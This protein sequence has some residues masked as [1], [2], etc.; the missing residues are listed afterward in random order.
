MAQICGGGAEHVALAMIERVIDWA[1]RSRGWILCGALVLATL[2]GVQASRLKLDALPDLSDNQIIVRA[3]FPGR[4][5]QLVEDQLTYPLTTALLGLPGATAV[6]GISM[7]GEAYVYVVLADSVAA[8]AVRSRVLER[9]SQLA[10]TLPPGATTA[11][12]PDASGVGWIFQYA[13]LAKNRDITP[14]RL[15]SLQEFVIKPELQ[16]VQG[17]AEVATFGAAARQVQVELDANRL[18]ALGISAG[19]VAEAVRNAN[20]AAGGG[21]LELGRQRVLISADARVR[22]REELLDIPIGNDAKGA[23]LRLRQVANVSYGPAPQ[24]GIADLN[25]AGAVVSGIVVMRKGENADR[26]AA[27]VK[28]AIS[29]LQT[30]LPEGVELVS[31]YDRTKIIHGAVRSLAARLIEEAI[32]VALVCGAFLWRVRSALVIILTLPIGLLCALALLE[33]QDVTANIMSLGGLAIAIGAMV[34]AAV[35]MV[36]ALHRKLERHRAADLSHREL[37][38]ETAREVGPA[39]FFSLLVITLSFLPVLFLQGQEGKLF[40][41][42]ALTKTYAMAAAALLSITLVPVLMGMLIKGPVAPELRNPLN[43]WLMRGY[44]PLLQ[45]VLDRPRTMLALAAVVSVSLLFPLSKMGREFMPPLDEGDLLYMPTTLPDVSLDEAAE[46]LRV[47]DELIRQMPEVA[48]VHGKAGRSDSATDPAPLSMLETT[49]LLKPRAEWPEPITTHE[50][51][52][53]LDERVRLAGLTNSWGFPIATR[54]DMLATGVRTP[55]ALRISG[56]DLTRIQALSERAEE[57]LRGVPGIRA[58]F[59]ERAAS[60]RFLDVELDRTRANLYG[61]RASDL[62]DLIGGAVG[63]EPVDTLSVGRERYP[64]VVRFARAQRDS[65]G[66]LARLP[67]RTA[68]GAIVTLSQIASL[69]VVDGATEIRSENARPVGFVLLD[70]ADRDVGGVL[71]RAREA[72]DRAGLHEPGYTLSWVGQYQRLQAATVRL[73]G[74]SLV[75]LAAIVGVLYW[76]FRCWKRVGV[77]IGSMPFAAS[78]AAWT[79]Y[80]LGYQWSFATAVGFLALAG[81]AAEFCVVMLLYLDHEMRATAALAGAGSRAAS[82]TAVIRGALLRL[83]PKTMTVAVILGGLLPLMMSEGPGVDVMRPVA[84]PVIGGMLTAPLFSLLVVPALYLMMFGVRERQQ[85]VARPR[86]PVAID[87]MRGD[88]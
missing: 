77:V 30:A 87:T 85:Q 73:V 88:A 47:T 18:T 8:D 2:A 11:L 76:H 41:P 14:D 49:I 32:V 12:G 31:T 56:P 66:D 54:I 83:R 39:L 27:R 64:I 80:W 42:L 40:S 35:V 13:L 43:R 86:E 6:R 33:W 29:G 4:P 23:V 37:V 78:G 19:Q 20:R 24:L 3:S 72:L 21:A 10:P 58:A 36:E 48:L 84:A 74:I 82:R 26:V 28:S 1:L 60:G 59:A 46:V 75:T 65:L 70:V 17:V 25:G 16:S 34:D 63:G 53:R 55:L 22:S 71:A 9:L 61:V 57:V 51:I 68:S 15:R 45:A 67:V 81:V 44:R 50:L 38:R 62:T 5:P 7:F 79:T 52:R 69:R